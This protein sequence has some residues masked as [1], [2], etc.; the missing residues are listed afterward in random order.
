MRRQASCSV[1]SLL[2][3][4]GRAGGD[5]LSSGSSSV[6]GVRHGGQYEGNKAK[7]L[8][9]ASSATTAAEIGRAHV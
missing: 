4:R 3:S 5:G 8:G 6:G 9:A 7:A 1:R 2:C